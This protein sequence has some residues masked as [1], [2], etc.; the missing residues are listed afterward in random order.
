VVPTAGSLINFSR[1]TIADFC[2][3]VPA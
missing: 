2:G 1:V 3:I